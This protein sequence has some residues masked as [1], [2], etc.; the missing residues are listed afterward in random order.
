MKL[1]CDED[2]RKYARNVLAEM[3][4][5][6]VGDVT[7]ERTEKLISAACRAIFYQGL[8][9]GVRLYASWIDG[10]DAATLDEALAHIEKEEFGPLKNPE[11]PECGK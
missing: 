5:G 11:F 7:P 8:R 10:C 3:R 2:F 9:D 6:P 4:A 1:T